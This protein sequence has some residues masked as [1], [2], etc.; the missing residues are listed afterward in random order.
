MVALSNKIDIKT[1][2]EALHILLN[3]CSSFTTAMKCVIRSHSGDIRIVDASN[4]DELAR[5]GF[6]GWE[7]LRA[8]CNNTNKSINLILNHKSIG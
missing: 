3:Y 7:D 8:Y 1:T 5:L 2:T 4:R 6:D